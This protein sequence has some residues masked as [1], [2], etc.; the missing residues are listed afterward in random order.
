[1]T[2][3]FTRPLI[4]YMTIKCSKKIKWASDWQMDFN[5][6]KCRLLCITKKRKPPNFTYTAN[7]EALTRVPECDYLGVTCTETLRWGAHCS[8]IAAKA[9]KSLG[10]ITRSL[11]PCRAEVKERA[12]MTLVRPTL[13]YASFSWNP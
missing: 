12:Y 5:V 2:L 4:P 8:K 6:T 1:M 10:V 3:C 13:E 11:K 9:N 7:S